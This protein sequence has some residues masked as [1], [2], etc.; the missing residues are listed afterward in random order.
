MPS[1]KRPPSAGALGS[2]ILQCCVAAWVLWAGIPAWGSVY[3]ESTR[4]IYQ[5]GQRDVTLK[6]TNADKAQAA[7]VQLWMDDGGLDASE[8][9]GHVPFLINPPMAKIEAGKS[10]LA[11]IAFIGEQLDPAHESLYWLNVLEIPPKS[12]GGSQLSFA[13]RSRIKFFYRPKAIW[14]LEPFNPEKLQWRWKS[15]TLPLQIEARNTSAFHWTINTATLLIANQEYPLDLS[16]MLKPQQ[17]LG[18]SLREADV[19][20]AG[21]ARIRISV[22]NDY[23][24]ESKFEFEV[25][26]AW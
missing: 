6:L 2:R 22:I 19:P 7:L 1:L 11:R 20:L 16:A 13:I 18:F 24:G 4:V 10:Q 25:K 17:S 14:A 3:L 12:T 21:P 26:D 8:V 23:G 5:E 9:Q 15:K